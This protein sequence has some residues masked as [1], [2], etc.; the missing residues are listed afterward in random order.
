MRKPIRA[1][2]GTRAKVSRSFQL[3]APTNG[4][5]VGANLSEA[6]KKTAF[7]LDNAFPQLDY[8]R[9]R[10]GSQEHADGMAGAVETLIP[11]Y[12]GTA[13]KLFAC[14]DDK[15]YDVSSAGAVGPAAVSGLTSNQWEYVQFVNSGAT[16]LRLVNGADT[17]QLYSTAGG[18]STSPAITGVTDTN[19][20]HVWAYKNRLF[21]VEKNKLS[22]WYLGVSNIGGAATEFPLQGI[23]KLGGSLLLGASWTVESPAGYH[24]SC[25]FISDQG[26]VAVYNGDYP[27]GTWELTGIYKISIPLGKRCVFKAGGDLAIMTEDGIVPMSKVV[28]L[29]QVALQNAAVTKP[30]APAWRQ[31]V[32]NRGGISGWQIT[33]W[34]LESMGVVN[35]PKLDAG[36]K[37]QFIANVRTGAWARYLGWDANCFA[38]F[39]NALYYGASDGRVMRAEVGA[40]DDGSNYTTTI[41][42][43]F[44]N[45]DK[46]ASRKQTKLMKPYLS[47]NFSLSPQVTMRADF[48]TT[49]PEEPGATVISTSG[50]KWDVALWD[51]DVW[52]NELF[53]QT[54][55]IS[56][57]AIGSVISPVL[58]WTV[59]EPSVD[60]DVR[61][62]AMDIIYEDGNE[63]G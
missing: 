49:I 30:I 26:E 4:W 14:V 8:I 39:N 58:Q 61:L 2:S 50:A 43:S 17:P 16:W 22:A 63:I 1:K 19:L 34:P 42:P 54:N 18:W 15:I 33:I 13:S 12:D 3:P 25:V 7:V 41:F 45:I 27:G 29:D 11:F 56:T 53:G 59:S 23:F 32:L 31:A 46:T 48:D 28:T 21:F 57:P 44:T 24:E 60:P 40:A 38:V 51:V 36:D 5:Y 52:P 62:T 37:T 35:L 47:A 9:T 6:P 10:R 20:S 55:W